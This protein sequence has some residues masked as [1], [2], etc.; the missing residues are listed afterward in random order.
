MKKKA[1]LI[2]LMFVVP[3]IAMAQSDNSGQATVNIKLYPIQTISVN[4]QQQD[5]DLIYSTKKDYQEGVS[6]EMPDHLTIFSTGGFEVNMN[7][8]GDLKGNNNSSIE[9]AD[10]LIE[11]SKGS[12]NNLNAT[13][14]AEKL[15]TSA[16]SIIQSETGGVNQQFNIRYLAEGGDKYANLYSK[17]DNPTS[18][19]TT[20]IYSITAK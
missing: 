11:A 13:F 18:F 12:Q 16:T 4:P 15:G 8:T 9:A 5:V 7:A 14:S 17:D 6:T 20:V 2:L 19:S 10:I 1:Q 3:F